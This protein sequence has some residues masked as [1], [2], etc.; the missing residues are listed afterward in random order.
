VRRSQLLG[1]ATVL[2]LLAVAFT[3]RAGSEAPPDDGGARAA[4]VSQDARIAELRRTTAVEPCAADLGTALPDLVLPC[5]ADGQPVALHGPAP[6]RPTLVN[7]WASWCR[8]CVDEVPVLSAV[9][10]RAGGRLGLVGVLTQDSLVSAL[11]FADAVGMRWP[12]VV[13][14]DGTVMRAHAAGPPVTLFLTA[15]GELVHVERGELTSEAELEALVA[16]HLGV[17]P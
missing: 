13:D 16:E 15:E 7:V 17:S 4:A 11:S 8:P 12:S 2:V 1:L 9:A 5:L 3:V 6:G 10:E 14:D